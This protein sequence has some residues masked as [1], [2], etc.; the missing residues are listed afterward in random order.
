MGK[1]RPSADDKRL[2]AEI[3]ARC[4]SLREVRGLSLQEA[5]D[6][7]GFTKSHMWDFEQGHSVNPT[8]RMLIGLARAYGVSL[9]HIVG[10]ATGE[11]PL[12]HE[13]MRIAS[14]IDQLLRKSGR[15]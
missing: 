14:E 1:R 4:K 9:E 6:R 10:L 2:V 3:A 8:I 12:H 5:G 11:P 7:A 15:S 13:A